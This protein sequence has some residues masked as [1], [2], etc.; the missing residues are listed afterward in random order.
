MLE[1][2]QKTSTSTLMSVETLEDF[3]LGGVDCKKCDNKGYTVWKEEDGTLTSKEC[4]CMKQRRSLRKI[5]QSGMMDMLERYTF[6]NYQT[7]DEG[8]KRVR[9]AVESF[10]DS[11]SGWLHISGRSGSGKTHI[12]TAACVRLISKGNEVYYMSWRDESTVL[13]GMLTDPELYARKMDKLKK[14]KVL[15]IDDFFKGGIT[16]ADFRLAFEIINARY[17]DKGLRTIISSE[18]KM[19]DLMK[20]DEALAGRIYERSRG[21]IIE[22]PDVNWR[23]N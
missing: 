23:M 17:N 2:A 13:K 14:V 16:D 5:R 1:K 7:P 15:Y 4:S 9:R 11:D 18:V 8:R 12:C 20:I 22:T 21:Y 10:A 6:D 19:K 3:D